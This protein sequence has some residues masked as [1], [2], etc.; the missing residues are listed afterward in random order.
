MIDFDFLEK[1]KESLR[2][3]YLAAQPFPHLIID[4]FCEEEKLSKAYNSIPEL[5]NKSRDYAFAN[6][7]FEKSNYKV[8]S[9][10]LEEL[11]Y[12]LSSDRF[13]AILSFITAKKIFV[14]PKNH[15]GGLHQGKK[16]SFLDWYC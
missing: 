3:K 10:E 11:Y 14:D 13:N 8:L 16:N 1:N 7:K 15:G 12:D 2:I 9:P 4:N 6:N 5:E